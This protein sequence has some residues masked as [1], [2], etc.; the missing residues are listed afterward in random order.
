[1]VPPSSSRTKMDRRELESHQ[2]ANVCLVFSFYSL[3]SPRSF[4]P[5]SIPL[6]NRN[7]EVTITPG[8]LS[9]VGATFEATAHLVPQ[10]DVGLSAL[11]G[12]VSSTVFLNL[13]ASADFTATIPDIENP[14]PCVP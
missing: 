9:D 14:H 10:I 2:A 8:P 13:D 5:L 3:S 12:I 1:M 6:N 11:H 7:T 4:P